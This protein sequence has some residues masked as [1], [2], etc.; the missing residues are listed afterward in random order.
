MGTEISLFNQP[1]PAHIA[2]MMQQYSNIP[3][4]ATVPSLTFTGKVWTT[5]VNGEATK[6]TKIVDGDEIPVSVMNVVILDYAKNRGRTYYPGAYD[7][8]KTA[9][10]TCWSDDGKTPH[11][12][13]ET[14]QAK[15]CATCEWSKKGS[16]V[17]DNNKSV[18]ACSQHRMIALLPAN[19][20]DFTPL[21]MKIAMTS[22]WDQQS[23][24]LEAKGWR[25]FQNHIDYLKTQGYTN[26]AAFV[27]KMKFDPNEAFPKII[28]TAS[29]F[30]TPEEKEAVLPVALSDEVKKLLTGAYSPD[31]AAGMETALDNLVTAR[32]APAG[33]VKMSTGAQ[34]AHARKPVDEDDDD[35][36]AA[37]PVATAPKPKPAPA[38]ASA[39][40][41]VAQKPKTAAK[42]VEAVPAKAIPE[43]V[44]AMLD[45]WDSDDE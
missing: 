10:P 42:P 11:A 26:T 15:T 5:N 30:L 37:A 35:E 31:G 24:D 18:T 9:K 2:D 7:P 39:K 14:P 1:V 34:V 41:P 40:A 20:L 25:A 44:A 3:E 8:A 36:G 28:F 21:R 23:P 43:N 12:S 32:E 29:R 6:I 17:T 45:S 4:R 13:V 22:D 19:A 33:Q 38:G 16:K 27:T